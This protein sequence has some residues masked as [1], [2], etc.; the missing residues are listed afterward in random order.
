MASTRTILSLLAVPLTAETFAD[1]IENRTDISNGED[2]HAI[3]AYL[4]DKVVSQTI[5]SAV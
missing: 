1:G 3:V 4:H 2:A 5:S